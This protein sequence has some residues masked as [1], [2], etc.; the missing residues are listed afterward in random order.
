MTFST[1]VKAYL[2][3]FDRQGVF[4]IALIPAY[5]ARYFVRNAT[6]AVL[7]G[8]FANLADSLETDFAYIALVITAVPFNLLTGIFLA[9]TI[10]S[11]RN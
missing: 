6:I 7:L 8:A 10:D 5:C 4:N 2:M 11:L 3:P 9:A 1:A